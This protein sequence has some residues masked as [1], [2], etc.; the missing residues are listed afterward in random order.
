MSLGIA[1]WLLETIC[2]SPEPLIY[3]YQYTL[4][5]VSLTFKKLALLL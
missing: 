1:K 2:R 3:C 5:Y 4:G